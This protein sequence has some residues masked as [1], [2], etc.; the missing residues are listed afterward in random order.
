[1][2]ITALLNQIKKNQK[3]WHDD[4]ETIRRKKEMVRRNGEGVQRL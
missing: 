3:I 2:F 4:E 1:M